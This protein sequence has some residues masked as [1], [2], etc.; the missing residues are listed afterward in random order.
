MPFFFP[1]PDCGKKLKADASQIGKR[2]VCGQ[3]AAEVTIPAPVEMEEEEEKVTVIPKPNKASSS[4]PTTSK[5]TLAALILAA[6]A[7][8]LQLVHVPV[9]NL[10]FSTILNLLVHTAA[11]CFA[12]KGWKYARAA[13]SQGHSDALTQTAWL[14]NFFLLIWQP[15]VIVVILITLFAG[16]TGGLSGIPGMPDVNI[17]DLFKNMQNINKEIDKLAR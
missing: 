8:A 12:F 4:Q 1:C 3:C 17:G 16:P 13:K 15:L 11:L 5:E 2:A 6:F 9:F 10:I 7:I 14:I